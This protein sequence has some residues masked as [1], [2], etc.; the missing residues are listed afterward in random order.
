MCSL[1]AT[2]LYASPH[3]SSPDR[4]PY[5]MWVFLVYT[6]VMRKVGF[7]ESSTWSNRA[8]RQRMES[9]FKVLVSVHIFLNFILKHLHIIKLRFGVCSMNFNTHMDSWNYHGSLYREQ[10]RAPKKFPHGILCNH[11]LLPCQPLHSLI[12]SVVLLFVFIF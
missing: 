5:E 4:H 11:T 7:K 12:W 6:S 3:L 2:T 1:F 8:Q 10:F 9:G